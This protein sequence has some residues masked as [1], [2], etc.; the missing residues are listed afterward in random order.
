VNINKYQASPRN[1][2]KCCHADYPIRE[3]RL[4]GATRRIVRCTREL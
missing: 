4:S 1:E 2:D 3:T